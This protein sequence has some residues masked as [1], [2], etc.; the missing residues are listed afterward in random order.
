MKFKT[1]A[2]LADAYAEGTQ[3]YPLVIDNDSVAAY[4]DGGCVFEMHPA[5][6]L[7]EALKLLGISSEPA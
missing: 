4:D 5:E 3:T 2:E 6:L 1:L 7:E